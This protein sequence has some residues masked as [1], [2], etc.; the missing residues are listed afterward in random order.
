[1]HTKENDIF[2]NRK[3]KGPEDKNQKDR[4]DAE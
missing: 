3:E 4:V 2:K 1:M